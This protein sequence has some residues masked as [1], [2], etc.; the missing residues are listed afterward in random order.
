MNND[1]IIQTMTESFEVLKDSWE[2]KKDSI[3]RCI[4]ET[5][6]CDGSLAMDMWVY[7]LSN[8]EKLLV[9][10]N[11]NVN[12]VDDVILGFRNKYKGVSNSDI[13]FCDVILNHIAPHFVRNERLIKIVF[14]LLIN[15][16]YS[17]KEYSHLSIPS[18]LLPALIACLF[19]QD[20]P[21]SIPVIIKSLA[22]NKNM[23]DISVGKLILKSNYYIDGI[24]NVW[25]WIN[26]KFHISDQ[27]KENLLNCLDLINDKEG[28]AEIALSLMAR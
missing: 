3:I 27:V 21:S 6:A 19:L 10:K 1:I 23:V 13:D 28:R 16:G 4:V 12:F 15:A 18:E 25:T 14:G 9:D 2:T 11:E 7:I 20:Y 17:K 24:E 5:E 22:Q 26:R 8:N